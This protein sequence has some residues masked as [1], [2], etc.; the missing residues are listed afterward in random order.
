M[1]MDEE[2]PDEVPTE[3]MDVKTTDTMTLFNN[4]KD[5]S[6]A[7]MDLVVDGTEE[8]R[9]EVLEFRRER[10]FKPLWESGTMERD[11]V[12]EKAQEREDDAV[13]VYEGRISEI[14]EEEGEEISI[15][16]FILRLQGQDELAEALLEKL[17]GADA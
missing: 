1:N 9:E 14:N 6:R 13:E 12:L 11:Y 7:L 4:N 8:D 3:P 16:D 5:V 10:L 17:V 15:P 2:L